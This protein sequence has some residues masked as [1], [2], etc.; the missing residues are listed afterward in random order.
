MEIKQGERYL[1]VVSGY[2]DALEIDELV[3]VEIHDKFAKVLDVEANITKW[4]YITDLETDIVA[5]LPPLPQQ[6]ARFTHAKTAHEG[7]WQGQVFVPL[8]RISA[9][10]ALGDEGQ[11]AVGVSVPVP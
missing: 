9:Q 1:A 11:R 2:G 5:N 4:R 10:E 7:T 8:G 6:H 3:I